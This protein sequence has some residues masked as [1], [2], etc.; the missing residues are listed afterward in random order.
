MTRLAAAL[1]VV[2]IVAAA[3]GGST[4]TPTPPAPPT[5]GFDL[6]NFDK[7]VRPQDDFYKCD[8]ERARAF[9]VSRQ[10]PDVECRRVLHGVRRQ[11]G[12]QDVPKA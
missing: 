2:A 8:V 4:P 5:S 10:H 9:E 6:A 12:R 7:S 3:C 11:T 1:I